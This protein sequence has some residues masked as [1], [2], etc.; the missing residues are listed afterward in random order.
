MARN[1]DLE[2]KRIRKDRRER[3]F[4][5]ILFLLVIATTT[6]YAI[7]PRKDIIINNGP[8]AI[9]VWILILITLKLIYNTLKYFIQI[10]T[11][12]SKIKSYIK[13]KGLKYNPPEKKPGSKYG[14]SNF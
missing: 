12:S 2:I 5:I 6:I 3:I 8:N 13:I 14:I 7:I 1:L 10:G 4:I 9:Y 11:L